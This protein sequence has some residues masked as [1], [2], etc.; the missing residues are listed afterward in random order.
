VVGLKGYMTGAGAATD[1]VV[2]KRGTDAITDTID[3]SALSDK[4]L[5][6]CASIDDA[7]NEIGASHSLN[8]VTASGALCR[9][10]VECEWVD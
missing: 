1:S 6:E 9:V 2:L 10:S 4:D 8:L 5:F 7:Y 3:V